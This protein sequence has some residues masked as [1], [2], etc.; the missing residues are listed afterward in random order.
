M[1]SPPTI[2]PP[3]I[4]QRPDPLFDRSPLPR[5]TEMGAPMVSIRARSGWQLLPVRDLWAFRELLL[6]L[7]WRDLKVRYK[8]TA[9]GVAWV[10][11]QPL[12]ATLIITLFMGRFA[13]LSKGL[14]VPYP[15]YV[16]SG[17]LPW[18]FFAN[19][20]NLSSNSL[21]SSSSL[22]SKVY[23]PRLLIPTASVGAGLMDFSVG[24]LVMGA[25]MIY[26]GVA[27][28]WSLLLLPILM[29]LLALLALSVG[30][31]MSALSV[32]YRD[33]RYVLPF[34]VQLWFFATPVFYATTKL[35]RF[36]VEWNPVTGL[37][38]AF[39]AILTGAPFEPRALAIAVGLTG[40]MLLFG[41]WNFRRLERDFADVI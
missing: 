7:V 4:F 36:L 21:I 31:T 22:I 24:F 34:V 38:G 29:V 32:R 40:L 35:P 14:S 19:S 9:L 1:K 11:L 39:R 27:L 10:I 37:L 23:F 33:V 18:T 30:L 16:Y 17:M 6:F 26:Y 13:E 5:E 12:A 25:M 3:D 8:Q 15:L 28:S 2:S 20:V 41:L